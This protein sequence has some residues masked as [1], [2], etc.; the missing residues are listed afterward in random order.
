MLSRS[1]SG[2]TGLNADPAVLPG[3]AHGAAGAD[4]LPTLVAAAHRRRRL[5]LGRIPRSAY[6]ENLGG[7][8]RELHLDGAGHDDFGDLGVLLD[9]FG[10][11]RHAYGH[12]GT[13][14]PTR[15]LAVQAAYV[16]AFFTQALLDVR[17]PLL[18]RPSTAFPEV[19]FTP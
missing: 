14:E 7:W 15:A 6:W 9:Q 4:R 3:R 12:F 10:V 1:P 5:T 18:D 11:D 13:I 2:V 8:R 19:T 16:R 17:R